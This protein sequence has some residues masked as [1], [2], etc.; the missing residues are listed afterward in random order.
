MLWPKLQ[1]P[2]TGPWAGLR[3]GVGGA[4]ACLLQATRR[5]GRLFIFWGWGERA[6]T[7]AR[8][9]LGEP[10]GFVVVAMVF[11]GG[12]Q[13]VPFQPGPQKKGRNWGGETCSVH[14]GDLD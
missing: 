12:H 8:P 6:G 4:G 3:P 1:T 9:A 13:P 10:L 14:F 11:P 2:P 7:T 5:G